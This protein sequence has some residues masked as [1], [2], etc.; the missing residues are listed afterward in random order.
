MR[1]TSY[2][3]AMPHAFDWQRGVIKTYSPQP[4]PPVTWKR[5]TPED[6]SADKWCDGVQ[7]TWVTKADTDD[8]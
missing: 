1:T 5:V 8:T 4:Y 3:A 7:L 2:L 6:E